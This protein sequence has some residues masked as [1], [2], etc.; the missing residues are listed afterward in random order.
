MPHATS[1]LKKF[2]DNK[3]IKFVS[4]N[5]ESKTTVIF[6]LKYVDMNPT[7]KKINSA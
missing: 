4:S 1:D 3:V 5:V 7:D 2:L 6:L